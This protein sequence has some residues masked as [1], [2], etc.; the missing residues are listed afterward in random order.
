MPMF[1]VFSTLKHLSHFLKEAQFSLSQTR[2]SNFVFLFLF[3]FLFQPI[4][5]TMN[6]LD[7]KNI[8]SASGI[9][10]YTIIYTINSLEMFKQYF[11]IEFNVPELCMNNC[12]KIM[13]SKKKQKYE[14]YTVFLYSTVLMCKINVL[15]FL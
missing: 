5:N 3:F 2:Q 12:V 9:D 8:D 6:I 10:E 1:S 4:T 7:M 13:E 14:L 15:V 11:H